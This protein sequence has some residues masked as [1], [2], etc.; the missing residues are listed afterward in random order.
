[1]EVSKTR[2][3]ELKKRYENDDFV[4]IYNLSSVPLEN[5]PSE[6]EVI[7]FYNNTESNLKFYPLERVLYW[8]QQDI[9]Y[10]KKSGLSEHG[11]RKIKQEN[12]IVFFDLVLIDGSEFTSSAE[13]DEIYGAKYICLD[14][15]NTFKNYRNHYKLISDKNYTLIEQN[16]FIRNGY[17]IF[18]KNENIEN[19]FSA[20]H[21]TLPALPIHFFTI[22]LNGQ[23]FIRYH[24]EIFKQLPFKWHWHIVEGVADLNHDTS[25][26]VKL[27]GCIS[28]EIHQN[29]HSCDGTTEYLDELAELYPDNITIYRQ[30]EGV[31]WDGK[32]EMVNAPLANIQEECLLWQIDVDELW[33]LDQICTGREIF[34]SNPEKT[35]AFYWCW[36]FVGEQLIISTRNCYAQNPQQEWLRTWRYKP[37]AFWVAHE[38]PVLVETLPDGQY[39]NVA[40]ANP[41]LHDETEQHGLVFQH[42]AYVTPE[43]L[44]FKE[45]YYGYSNAVAQW[46]SLQ[47]TNNFPVLLREY[48][49]WVRDET[50]VDIAHTR[51]IIPIAQR[52]SSSNIWR[53]LQLD[54]VQQ[55]ITQINK[56]SPIIIVDGVFFQLYKTGIARVWKSLLEE[57]ANNGF[58]K[59]IILLDRA[60]TAPKIYGIRYRTVP[61]YDYDN[62]DVDRE[63]LQQ[64]CDEESAD[65]FISTYYTTPITTPSVFMA[66]DMI[67]EVMGW[68]MNHP[69][70][71]E[72]QQG[73]RHASAYITISEHTAYDLVN[74]YND[75]A[76]EAVTVAYCG[77]KNTFLPSKPEEINSFRTKYG[78][79]KPY[80][81]VVGGGIGYKNSILFFQA[82][83]QLASSNGFDIVCTGSDGVLAPEFRALTSGSVVHMLQLSDEELAIAYSGAVTFVYPS[84]Y[85]GFGLPVL[86]AMACGCPVITCP[87]ASLP[88]VAGEAAIYIKDDDVQALV[89]ALCEVQKPSVRQSLIAAGLEQA[90]KFS[91]SKMANIVT[92]VLIDATFTSLRL[93]DTNFII[94]PDWSQS[95][96]LLSLELELVIKAIAFSPDSE[97]ITLLIYTSNISHEDAQL[98]LS[99]V[100]MNLL[101]Q[102]DADIYERLEISLVGYFS[103]IQWQ[104]LLPRIKARIILEQENKQAIV[105]LKAEKLISYSTNIFIEKLQNNLLSEDSYNCQLEAENHLESSQEAISQ[106]HTQALALYHNRQ[107]DE[108]EEKFKEVLQWDNHHA[109]AWLNIGTLYYIR[110]RY[111][112]ALY[113]LNNCLKIEPSGAIQHYSLGLVLEKI[114]DIPQAI[115]AYQQAIFLDSKLIDAY[116]KLGNIFLTMGKLEEAESIYRQAIAANPGH[117]GSHINLGNVILEKQQ[118]DDAIAAYEKALELKPRNPDI[119]YNLG[120]AFEA[121]NDKAEAALN[122]GYAFYRQGKS[123]EAVEKFLEFLETKTGDVFLYLALGDCYKRLQKDEEAIKTYQAGIKLYPESAILYFELSITLQ[124]F[125]RPQEAIAV[126]EQASQLL[127]HVL[128]LKIQQQCTLPILYETEAEIDYYRQRFTQGL[129]QLIQQ[130]Y[131]ESIEDKS[132]VLS[133]IACRTNFYLQYQGKDDLS[134]QKKYGHFVHKVMAANYP[135]WVK[136][137]SMPP[138]SNNGKI[139]IGY[140]S[141][142]MRMHTVGR[143]M[144]G[145]LRNRNHQDFE[146]YCYHIDPI[147]DSITQQYRLYSD[148][149]RHI[150]QDLES[151]CKNIISDQLHIL[152]I[153]DIGMQPQLSQIAGLRLAPI[154]CTSWGHPITSGS[155]TIDYFLTSDLMEPENSQAHYSEKLV[156]LPNIGISYAQP[157]IPELEKSRIDFGLTEESILYLSCQSLYKYLPQYDYIFAAIAQ[158]VPQAQFAFLSHQSVYITD[159]FR[160]RLQYAF[161]NF[162]LNSEEYCVIL[163]RLK[164]LE[165]LNLN[166]ISDIFLDTFSWSGGNTAL[167]AIACKLPIVTCP[168]KFMRGRHSYGILQMLGVTDTI[169]KNEDEYIEIAVKLG[170][171]TEWRKS[172]VEQMVTRHSYLYNDKTC[173]EA[174]EDFYR[175]V[176]QEGLKVP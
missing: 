104:A 139:R 82:F 88:E 74:C 113:A 91:W 117:F 41:F 18:K 67:P 17:S 55:E 62:T 52:E 165:Y 118:V 24:I 137:I 149:F 66:Y 75:V 127:P 120:V 103:E 116:N 145:W 31:F 53:F 150:P 34:I 72:K 49:S 38:P 15:I 65:I 164:W 105:E 99:G 40:T 160:R 83:Y 115:Q 157:I 48:F 163:P 87:N 68:D 28:D 136:P 151:V 148:Y 78:I 135:E 98:F 168:G 16:N 167:E 84:K 33:T 122:Y 152:V 45:Q 2:F 155:P 13:L 134:L 25:W 43:Q 146:V 10:V 76:R 97:Q 5:F 42:F 174:L 71:R 175:R 35:A 169:A 172:I 22:V 130:T 106:L 61:A 20:Y 29:G 23:P 73:I 129:E 4:K 132:N 112:E 58:A 47:K 170:L 7:E 141:E 9:D 125:G 70:W 92:S 14:D 30:P 123:Q 159:K 90:K 36:Y 119:L 108:A 63:I 69:M 158:K 64:V 142:C 46:N 3:T 39:K 147:V 114:D 85:E 138:V 60:G 94:F 1:M 57:W 131:L 89:D 173:V 133:A 81:M 107:L 44:R 51:R 37:G 96:K 59:H 111:Q 124:V 93:K 144:L 80:F 176:V 101:M 109:A 27:G 110:E 95:E 156:R 50:Q 56:V 54:E 86:E 6:N 161:A 121:K 102:T 100:T 12:D 140:V 153:L 171:E 19:C 162:G 166:C 77:V 32:R 79:S 11:I 154:Q 128:S 21:I 8:L 143:L 26:S 126:A